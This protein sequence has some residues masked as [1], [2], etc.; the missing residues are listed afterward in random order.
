[1]EKIIQEKIQRATIQAIR[2]KRYP[3]IHPTD[4]TLNTKKERPTTSTTST[5]ATHLIPTY[6]I[7]WLKIN[8]HSILQDNTTL[9]KERILWCE[10]ILVLFNRYEQGKIQEADLDDVF[11]HIKRQHVSCLIATLP[12][13]L[14]FFEAKWG[15]IEKKSY[16]MLTV[17]LAFYSTMLD[18]QVRETNPSFFYRSLMDCIL[19]PAHH[20][21]EGESSNI[22]KQA[23]YVLY[24]YVWYHT[25]C[26]STFYRDVAKHSKTNA[27]CVALAYLC[28][29]EDLL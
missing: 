24:K 16:R 13:F 26:R 22:T 4:L 6:T 27:S 29:R 14:A 2:L 5:S 17:M 19:H 23:I 21:Q 20:L 18:S 3:N 10:E 7:E 15:A 8:G 11:A 28:R 12:F 1:M 9:S 25:S